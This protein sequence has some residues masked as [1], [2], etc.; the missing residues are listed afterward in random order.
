MFGWNDCNDDTHQIPFHSPF[1]F[2]FVLSSVNFFALAKMRVVLLKTLKSTA[3][4][5]WL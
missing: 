5:L 1:F 3:L 4:K 2:G